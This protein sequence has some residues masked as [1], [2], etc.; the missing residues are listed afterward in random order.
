M[1]RD[2]VQAAVDQIQFARR[3]TN[4]FL[5]DLSAEEWFWQPA[6]GVTHIGWQVGH[7]A[8]SQYALCLLRQRGPLDADENLIPEEFRTSFG[9]GSEP[10]AGL[11]NNLAVETIQAVFEGVYKQV[12]V[13]LAS[14]TDQQLD[15]PAGKP[16]PVFDTK[17]GAIEWASGHELVHAGQIALLRRLMGKKPLR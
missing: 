10:V 5:A 9:K 7:L 13:E 14:Q 6:E 8:T 15:V 11:Q 3:F 4:T 17:L 2:R 16:H 12:E 1:S